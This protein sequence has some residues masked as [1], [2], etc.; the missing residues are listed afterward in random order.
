VIVTR[1]GGRIR[2]DVLLLREYWREGGPSA[3][4]ANAV[5]RLRRLVGRLRR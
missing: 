1:S 4:W 5:K 2:Q 3:V